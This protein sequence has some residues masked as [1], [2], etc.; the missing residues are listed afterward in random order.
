MFYTF[1]EASLWDVRNMTS[2]KINPVLQF[3]HS[4][5]LT[6]AFFSASGSKIVTTSNDN[7][8]RIFNTSKLD[9]DSTSKYKIQ[10]FTFNKI[11]L[12]PIKKYNCY[13]T[14]MIF[15]KINHFTFIRFNLLNI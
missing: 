15:F 13:F 8:L 7:Y 4:K 12:S 1:S 6:S 9:I 5:A 10:F 3:E 14:S 11:I 2:K